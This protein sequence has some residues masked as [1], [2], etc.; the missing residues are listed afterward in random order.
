MVAVLVVAGSCYYW[1]YHAVRAIRTEQHKKAVA[2][3]EAIKAAKAKKLQSQLETAWQNALT[4]TPADGYVDVAVYDN[5]TGMT[6]H[7]TNA[8][9]GTTYNTASIIKLSILETLLWQ[10]QKN[11]VAQL[12]AS[13][14]A[15]ATPMIAQS[16]NDAATDLWV[17]VGK[18]PAVN[19]FF[20]QV[21]ATGSTAGPDW[22]LTKTTA[23][24]QLQ[25]INQV[26]YPGKLL[27]ATSAQQA[28]ALLD[29]VEATQ[30][31]G[32]SGGVPTGV[33]VRLKNGWLQGDGTDFSGWEV[34]SVGHVSGS[35]TDYTI[36]ALTSGDKTEQ[37]GINTIQALSTLAWQTVSIAK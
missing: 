17:L 26:A 16:D 12:T 23:V 31:W 29:Q 33:S 37:N 6:A 14:L 27:T 35:G 28:N 20:Q 1:G 24:D 15:N 4:T 3:Q 30:H 5:G 19:S 11:G 18:G 7:Y 10:N 36:A 8:P 25:V 34:N 2:S 22:G 13:Q 21:G 9:A 32:V